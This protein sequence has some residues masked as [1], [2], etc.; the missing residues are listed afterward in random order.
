MDRNIRAQ[1][2]PCLPFQPTRINYVSTFYFGGYL[3]YYLFV[4]TYLYF[5]GQMWNVTPSMFV[6]GVITCQERHL[7][8]AC[9]WQFIFKGASFSRLYFVVVLFPKK[10]T[11]GADVLFGATERDCVLQINQRTICF[12]WRHLSCPNLFY[13]KLEPTVRIHKISLS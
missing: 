4:N 5:L 1:Y 7:S 8:A 13:F 3:L 9:Y 12:P 2:R 11:E 10:Q 6:E